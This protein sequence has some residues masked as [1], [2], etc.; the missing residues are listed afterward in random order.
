MDSSHNVLRPAMDLDGYCRRQCLSIGNLPSVLLPQ[1]VVAAQSPNILSP[2]ISIDRHVPQPVDCS[3]QCT[4]IGFAP[5]PLW[6]QHMI[7]P[8]VGSIVSV[9][10]WSERLLFPPPTRNFPIPGCGAGCA[11]RNES[12]NADLS[13][14]TILARF[15]FSE[16]FHPSSSIYGIFT[17]RFSRGSAFFQ[18]RCLGG[19]GPL[20]S[21]ARRNATSFNK[22]EG[23]KVSKRKSFGWYSTIVEVL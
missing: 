21:F 9:H 12:G 11:I 17:I 19:F 4:W 5:R 13:E 6:K 10:V 18:H 23:T 2:T 1:K 15:I 22:L 8:A 3:Q 16:L 7:L 20:T 14:E